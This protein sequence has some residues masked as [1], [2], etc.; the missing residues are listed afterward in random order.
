MKSAVA[1]AAKNHTD[2]IDAVE[3]K[4]KDVPDRLLLS[5]DS[6]AARVETSRNTIYRAIHAGHLELV[7]IGRSSRITA[8]SFHRWVAGF[9]RKA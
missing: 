2:E 4:P 8:D 7:H 1:R 9:S 6:A 5:V 3:R